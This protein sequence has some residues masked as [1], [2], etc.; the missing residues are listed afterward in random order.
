MTKGG[1]TGPTLEPGKGADSLLY[2][3][4]VPSAPGQRPE[5]PL[6]KQPLSEAETALIR[7]WI[8]SGAPWPKEIILKERAKADKSFWSF[9]PLADVAPP[10]TPD[11]PVTWQSHPIDRFV[12]AALRERG[13]APNPPAG[14]RELIRRMTYDLTG[15]PPSP[16]D[17]TSTVRRPAAGRSTTTTPAHPASTYCPTLTVPTRYFRT[18]GGRAPHLLYSR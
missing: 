9:Q 10:A 15:L 13:L 17:V 1:D 16:E 6:K 14:P 2:T 18:R 11:A 3:M 12:F 7:R 4:I 5:M 8:D